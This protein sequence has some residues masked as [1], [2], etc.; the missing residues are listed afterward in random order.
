MI[1]AFGKDSSTKRRIGEHKIPRMSEPTGQNINLALDQTDRNCR[2]EIIA[3]SEWLGWL[4]PLRWISVGGGVVLS[5]TA[6]FAILL[7]SLP[8]GKIISASL[9]FAAS[10]MTGLHVA[11]KCD[12]HQA[13]CRRLIQA[14]RSLSLQIAACK[15]LPTV[16]QVKARAE[17]I[18]KSSSPRGDGRREPRRVVLS[19]CRACDCA[20]PIGR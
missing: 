19:S 13:E 15:E 16:E 6:G 9:A 1:N 14:F 5:A 7:D 20:I 18:D 12:A 11:L 10:I 3:Y 2:R 8:N 4:T 17:I